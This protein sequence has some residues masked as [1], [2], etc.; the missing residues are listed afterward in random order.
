MPNFLKSIRVFFKGFSP[1]TYWKSLLNIWRAGK[2]AKPYRYTNP[3]AKA[4]NIE[5]VKSI[6]SLKPIIYRL[7]WGRGN[8]YKQAIHFSIILITVFTVLSGVSYR[9]SGLSSQPISSQSL[10]AADNIDVLE[11]GASIQAVLT[12]SFTSR[13]K[14]IEHVVAEGES[15]DSIAAKYKVSKQTIKDSNTAIFYNYSRYTSESVAVGEKYLIPEIDGVIYEIQANDNLDGILGKTSGDKF[16]TVELN[17]ISAPDYSLAGVSKILVPNGKLAAP[18]PPPPSIPTYA[19]RVPTNLG[20]NADGTGDNPL[21]GVYFSNPLSNPDCAGYSWSRGYSSYHDG[22]DLGKG[23]GCPIRA[24]CSG[25]VVWA[26]WGSP[27]GGNFGEG[28]NV[29]IECGGGVRTAYYHGDGNIWV[30]V[31]QQVSRG[32]EIMYMGMS[33]GTST[34]VHLHL[35]LR[36]NGIFIDPAYYI[37]Y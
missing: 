13:F 17:G 26:G 21:N 19:Y 30:N 34:G 37:P 24:A 10:T 32:Q 15:L 35:G 6:I 7:Y 25:T 12:N 8:F 28:F 33:G 31:G 18:T 3:T 36:L 2:F 11:Q 9:L 23:G 14:Y 4:Q 20:V 27:G 16:L 5:R 1:A 29:A 22:V